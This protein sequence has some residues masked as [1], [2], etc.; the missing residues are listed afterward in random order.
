M[1]KP[2][3]PELKSS[4][5]PK[6]AKQSI[7]KDKVTE[8]TQAKED[9]RISEENFLSLISQ[10]SDGIV[11]LYSHTTVFANNRICKITG[12]S[13]DEILGKYFME[14][15]APEY[16]ELLT[17]NYEMK[18]VDGEPNALEM[19]I[20]ASDGRKIAV[21][22]R[23]QSIVFKGRA[24][25]MV[26]IRDITERKQAEDALK[27]SEQNFRNSMD[28]SS[29][30][31]RIGGETEE[32]FYVNKAMLDIFGYKNLDEIQKKPPH[33]YYSSESQASYMV[34]HEKF[35][36]GEPM[37]RQVDIDIIRKDGTTREFRSFNDGCILE[38][39]AAASDSL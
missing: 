18:L 14:L 32:T 38:W 37:P 10:N 23:A 34:R 7:L 2:D 19:K 29:I 17:A 20:I 26:I 6:G 25:T 27:L 21:E 31:I 36:R 8:P 5:S 35:L 13:Q 9:L 11:I 15:V 4:N 16:Q 39:K 33:E 12:Y 28:K 22:T 3:R 1:N 30:G 24:A